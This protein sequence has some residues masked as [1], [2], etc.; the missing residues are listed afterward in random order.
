[1]YRNVLVHKRG[2]DCL[3]QRERINFK[4]RMRF[5]MDIGKVLF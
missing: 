3:L 2:E 4:S 1:M 5:K